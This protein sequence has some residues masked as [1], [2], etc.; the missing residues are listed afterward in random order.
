MRTLF[1][2][3][4]EK[5]ALK[6]LTHFDNLVLWLDVLDW[7]WLIEDIFKVV[8]CVAA[9]TESCVNTR[10]VRNVALL[11]PIFDLF[12]VAHVLNLFNIRNVV[13][14]SVCGERV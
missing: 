14:L 9:S 4:Y 8:I 10:L 5:R 2:K 12:P 3:F 11:G 13:A 1:L 6:N 7:L